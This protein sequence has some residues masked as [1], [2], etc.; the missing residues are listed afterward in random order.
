MIVY[1]HC[2][3][4]S[5]PPARQLAYHNW[6][7]GLAQGIGTYRAV[8]ALEQDA[9]ISPGCLSKHGLAVRM[10]ELR[11]AINVLSPDCPHL[12][13]YVDAGAADALPA[14]LAA[15]LLQQA[16]VSQIQGFFL[17]ATHF[18]W[19]SR[20]IKYGQQIST[21]LGGTHSIVRTGETGQG[22]LVPPNEVRNGN[23]VLCNP[24]GHGLGPK[25]TTNTAFPRDD[26]FVWLDNP[27]GSSG[28][29]VPGAPPAGVYWPK[30]ALMLI[31]NANYK[32]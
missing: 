9:L 24:P 18:D 29:C 3:N 21:L 32:V 31:K 19:T 4:W 17:D 23:E 14:K 8:L 27:G 26:A 13:I 12:V 22:P 10:A 7:V 6:I 1:G 15:S 16:G 30:Y 2:G 5:D 25:P 28:A 11:D 20:E